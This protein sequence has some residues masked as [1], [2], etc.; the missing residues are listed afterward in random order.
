MSCPYTNDGLGYD[1]C[2]NGAVK[3]N[4]MSYRGRARGESSGKISISTAI[5]TTLKSKRKSQI[6][7]LC[8]FVCIIYTSPYLLV[9]GRHIYF[10]G[11][12]Q[13]HLIAAVIK[14]FRLPK[15]LMRK[16]ILDIISAR[17]RIL[18][19]GGCL[20]LDDDGDINR[21]CFANKV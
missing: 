5:N 18:P 12:G 14:V 17:D 10:L 21:N 1:H 6:K 9:S 3:I 15:R 11:R 19:A 16:A 2:S 7:Q 8:A 4:F 13:P 20:R